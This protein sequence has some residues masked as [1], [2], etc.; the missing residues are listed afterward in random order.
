ML[1]VVTPQHGDRS[2]I[3]EFVTS[4]NLAYPVMSPLFRLHQL[5]IN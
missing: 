5:K 3:I 4:F 1:P 2:M